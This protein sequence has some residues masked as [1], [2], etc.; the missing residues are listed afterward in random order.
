VHRYQTQC[1]ACFLKK[2]ANMCQRWPIV[3]L[4]TE[5][6]WGTNLGDVS[7][8]HAWDAFSKAMMC[9]GGVDVGHINN[10]H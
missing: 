10:D 6:Q 4:G 2:L 7:K 8:K 1:Q 5:E 3:N 9:T